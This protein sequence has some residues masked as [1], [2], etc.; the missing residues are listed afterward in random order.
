MS[1][2][3]LLQ[4]IRAGQLNKRFYNLYS[5]VTLANVTMDGTIPSSNTRQSTFLIQIETS[6]NLYK[7]TFPRLKRDLEYQ[8]RRDFWS[9]LKWDN[10]HIFKKNKRRKLSQNPYEFNKVS[11][12][13]QVSFE[14]FAEVDS[15]VEIDGEIKIVKERTMQSSIYLLG[16]VNFN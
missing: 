4:I 8:P 14:F 12:S 13:K 3:P 16:G 5:P 9:K 2:L 10:S 15:A 11:W 6:P 1:Y 7:L